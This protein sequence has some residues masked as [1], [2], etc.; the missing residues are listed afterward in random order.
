[1]LK[2]LYI[3]FIKELKMKTNFRLWFKYKYTSKVW[4]PTTQS[5]Y[6]GRSNLK[7]KNINL[8][9][10]RSFCSGNVKLRAKSFLDVKD[11]TKN[12]QAES[13]AEAARR[14]TR[15]PNP[16]RI[17][18][19]VRRIYTIFIE[20]DL[21]TKINNMNDLLLES[22]WTENQE[23]GDK[24]KV[25]LD[26][27]L[28]HEI[29]DNEEVFY[30]DEFFI[31]EGI[32]LEGLRLEDLRSKIETCQGFYTHKYSEL[33]EKIKEWNEEK[34][35]LLL[36]QEEES[37]KD[38]GKYPDYSLHPYMLS[39]NINTSKTSQSEILKLI[40]SGNLNSSQKLY[41]DTSSSEK[42]GF[43]GN[44]ELNFNKKRKFSDLNG[45]D[46]CDEGKIIKKAK[47]SDNSS[48]LDDYADVS[49]EPL[50]IIDLDG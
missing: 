18:C 6:L 25:A 23:M 44:V 11:L 4:K 31:K 49:C 8:G 32:S 7:K 36:Q 33:Q 47:I 21:D 12:L 14:I 50:D 15:V 22:F 26:K 43:S 46:H 9:F 5:V 13:S 37:T 38:K 24:A 34:N 2:F 16:N 48:L 30:V 3:K 19:L 17:A 40:K 35:N 42:L 20:S 27:M 39:E 45:I 10:S 28:R 41:T 29:L 1:M